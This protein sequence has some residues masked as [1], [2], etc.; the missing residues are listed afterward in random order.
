MI[1]RILFLIFYL[2]TF[3]NAL[4]KEEYKIYNYINTKIIVFDDK[5][6]V[7]SEKTYPVI[8]D[9]QV[10]YKRVKCYPFADNNNIY[11]ASILQL[12]IK[13]VL[14]GYKIFQEGNKLCL[15]I[16]GVKQYYFVEGF[17]S[18]NA[19]V[20]LEVFYVPNSF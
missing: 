16:S 11:K 17:D 14:A 4:E 8:I 18:S 9:S 15:I 7:Y 2:I 13:D 6:T 10:E 1:K 20:Y 19:K 12:N 5:N 3:S